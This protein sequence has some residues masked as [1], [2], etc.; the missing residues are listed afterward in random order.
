MRVRSVSGPARC[1]ARRRAPF[2]VTVRSMV[3]SR[4]LFARRTASASIRGWPAWR[5][6]WR[7]SRRSPR[8]SARR[9][10]RGRRVG[11]GRYIGGPFRRRDLRAAEPAEP[12]EGRDTVLLADSP[13]GG[14]GFEFGLGQRHHGRLRILPKPRQGRIG[15]DRLRQHDLARIVPGHGAGQFARRDL[16]QGEPAGGDVDGREA[17]DEA[18]LRRLLPADGEQQVGARGIEEAVLG[19]GAGV[20]RRTTSRRTTDFGLRFLAS[21]GS[22]VCSQ[23]ATRCPR[24]IRRLR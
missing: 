16:A 14:R 15:M 11:C 5:H 18:A 13:L 20:T 7:E 10:A 22:S 12:V 2:A 17:V 4:L 6:R 1:S 24:A 21:A 8:G 9:V 19:D 3:A 23:T